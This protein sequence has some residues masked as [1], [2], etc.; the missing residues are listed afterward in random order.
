[1]FDDTLRMPSVYNNFSFRR[2]QRLR[3]T[4]NKYAALETSNGNVKLLFL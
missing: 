3:K 1:M 4:L 2:C